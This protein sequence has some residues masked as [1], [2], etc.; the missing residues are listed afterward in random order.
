M[1]HEHRW[2]GGYKQ[3]YLKMFCIVVIDGFEKKKKIYI[4][5]TGLLAAC[6]TQTDRI[7]GNPLYRWFSIYGPRLTGER[8]NYIL[9]KH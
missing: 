5:F 2:F 9:A 1:L 8:N 3:R 7:K 4:D 6:N